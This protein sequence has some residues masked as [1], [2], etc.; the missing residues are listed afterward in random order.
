MKAKRKPWEEVAQTATT[1]DG[2]TLQQKA[3]FHYFNPNGL[4]AAKRANDDAID[5]LVTAGV[6]KSG[7]II[8][9]G[10]LDRFHEKQL[11]KLVKRSKPPSRDELWL[12][13][14]GMRENVLRV[15]A[16]LDAVYM[17]IYPHKEALKNG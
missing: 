8:A 16:K 13:L 5:E 4:H 6:I 10:S 17:G 3:Q 1:D 11:Y 2:M 12:A 9:N 15:K 14:Y 7:W